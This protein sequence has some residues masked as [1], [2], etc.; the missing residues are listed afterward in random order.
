MGA[1]PRTSSLSRC[2]LSLAALVSLPSA[3]CAGGEGAA[4]V[5]VDFSDGG[6]A[7]AS[8]AATGAALA[9]SADGEALRIVA[10][11]DAEEVTLTVSPASGT[12]DLSAYDSVQLQLRNPGA[13]PVTVHAQVENPDAEGYR[14]VC[15]GVVVL[16]GG[17]R[18]VLPVKLVRRPADPGFEPFA[19]FLRYARNITVRDGTVDPA[20]IARIAVRVTGAPWPRPVEIERID[21][22][23]L[24]VPAPAPFFPFVDEYGQYVHAHWQ[25]KIYA[26]ADFADR[27]AE[28]LA[29]MADWPGPPEWDA[30]GGWADGPQ[31]EA[32]GHFY[33]TKREGKWWLVDPEGR[34][35]WS[36]GPTGVGFGSRT[37][38]TDRLHWFRPLPSTD[39][40]FGR[41]YGSGR[42][43]RDK[44][45]RGKSYETFDFAGANL[46]R[47]YGEGYAE[48][49]AGVS[50]QRLRSWGLN[51]IANWSDE[52]IYLPR[53]TPYVVAIHYGGPWLDGIPDA[54]D[55][56]FRRT[57]R[58]RMERERGRSADDPWC[59]GYFVDNELWWGYWDDAR[60]V[61]DGM[62]Q[63]GP[64][65]AK[66]A[67]IAG[68]KA[69]Y[70]TVGALND[71]WNTGYESWEALLTSEEAPDPENPNVAEDY[72]AFGL[73]FCERYFATVREEVKRVA[74]STLYLG[75]RFHGH[76]DLDLIEIAARYCDVISYNVY[77][78]TP[79]G[80]LDRYLGVV[81]MPFIVGEFGIGSDPGQTP[82][83]GKELS[84]DP[85]DRVRSFTHYVERAFVHPLM[86][87][88]H[89]FQY[90]DQA[91]TGRPDGEAV[92]RGLVNVADTPHFDL[93]RANR[94]AAYG[95]YRSRWE[96]DLTDPAVSD[97]ASA[98][99]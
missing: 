19:P 24:G 98:G 82:F 83:R 21:A 71:A 7:G 36:Y 70:G 2:A 99:R 10:V 67:F 53:R 48:A 16:E 65:A 79:G 60:M 4:R 1:A 91:L 32:T 64:T 47:K 44:Y 61:A 13:E 84:V 9:E 52:R 85:R 25:G 31:L 73:E 33:P 94:L 34:L 3:A 15:R 63:M 78:D 77:G 50:H 28:E 5:L 81:D 17:E 12:W 86:V 43:A 23:G 18:G 41:F 58:A 93:V 57:L 46:L 74:P 35:F 59:I 51:T 66:R 56:E 62:M 90:R 80:R 22:V 14:D 55:P 68:L 76:I 8:I 39:S 92:L 97:E 87:G 88:A 49:V 38:V 89:F 42:D 40:R 11:P 45:Y 54:F 96:S 37:P 30:Y 27:R 20:G 26:E 95:L 75:C 72:G 69:K 29:E 6:A